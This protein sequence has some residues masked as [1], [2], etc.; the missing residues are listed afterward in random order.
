MFVAFVRLRPVEFH[1][2]KELLY[3]GTETAVLKLG[4]AVIVLESPLELLALVLFHTTRVLFEA[5]DSMGSAAKA[6]TDS[7]EAAAPSD[8]DSEEEEAGNG[9]DDELSA[10]DDPDD[11]EEL[12][13]WLSSGS[14]A[15]AVADADAGASAGSCGIVELVNASVRNE[16]TITSHR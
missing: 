1:P 10:A 15:D 13:A 7:V 12:V 14:G 16:I 11:D 6:G 9:E 2:K 5:E 3:A 8:T 4:A